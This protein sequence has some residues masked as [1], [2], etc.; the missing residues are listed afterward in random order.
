MKIRYRNSWVFIRTKVNYQRIVLPVVIELGKAGSVLLFTVSSALCCHIYYLQGNLFLPAVLD[1]GG[2]H[3]GKPASNLRICNKF[4]N[5]SFY[6]LQWDWGSLK[7]SEKSFHQSLAARRL[8]TEDT[9]AR[10]SQLVHRSHPSW[11]VWKT[12]SYFPRDL[13]KNLGTRLSDPADS[14]RGLVAWL[15][16]SS[17]TWS[18][19]ILLDHQ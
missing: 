15:P 9:I 13:R 18:V 4:M 8:Y 19:N 16:F 3:G 6:Y 1:S 2:R 14:P 12:G 7:S 5:S 11:N 17:S 10:R